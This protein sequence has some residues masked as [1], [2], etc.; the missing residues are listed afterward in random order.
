MS[1]YTNKL[2]NIKSFIV[3]TL[4]ASQM[5]EC[6]N[7]IKLKDTSYQ[8]EQLTKIKAYDIVN[9]LQFIIGI[10][11]VSFGYPCISNSYK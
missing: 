11:P 8:N 1:L 7:K 9:D 10:T 3:L 4:K 2:Y 6:F 5:V